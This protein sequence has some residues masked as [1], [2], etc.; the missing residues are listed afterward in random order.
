MT[1]I[2]IKLAAWLF[3]FML[4]ASARAAFGQNTGATLP[5]APLQFENASG[6]VLA[7]GKICTYVSGTSTPLATFSDTALTVQNPNPILL[8]AAGQPS[9][10]G[11]AVSVYIGT[12]SYRV[13][14]RTA[15]TDNTCATG[16]VLYTR[17][18]V[19]DL[20]ALAS[21]DFNPVIVDNV[22]HCAQYAGATAGA[23]IVA[24]IAAVPSTGGTVDCRGLEARRAS[25]RTRS[26]A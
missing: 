7:S 23:R 6:A 5:W 26:P 20:A 14:A 15:G 2:I 10:S 13:V 3:F 1:R 16:T 9:V 18:G 22:H 4:M 21:Q 17:D 12:S 24:A 25:L 11:L 8:N 19:Y